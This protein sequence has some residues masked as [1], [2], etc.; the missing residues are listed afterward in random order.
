[1]LLKLVLLRLNSLFA[2]PSA[3]LGGFPLLVLQ[4]AALELAFGCLLVLVWVS[5]ER[6]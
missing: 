2:S 3:G 1:M 5:R 4:L 6:A